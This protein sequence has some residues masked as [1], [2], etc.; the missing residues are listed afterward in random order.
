MMKALSSASCPNMPSI[1]LENLFFPKDNLNT[2]AVLS[3]T[4]LSLRVATSASLLTAM[5]SLSMSM[6]AF[7]TW[8][9]IL[10]L[11]MSSRPFHMF[12]SLMPLSGILQFSTMN[13][14]TPMTCPLILQSYLDM[15]HVTPVSTILVPSIIFARLMN[16]T[17]LTC[18]T[19]SLRN[20]PSWNVQQMPY[21]LFHNVF[22]ATSAILTFSSLT[23]D[24]SVLIVFSAPLNTLHSSITLPIISLSVATSSPVFLLP[25][26]D[27]SLN[28]ILLIPYSVMFLLPMTAFLVM[29]AVLW[30]NLTVAL[31]HTS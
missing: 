11:L 26:Y 31:T 22:I 4:H 23:S 29:V 5:S 13:F 6:T 7:T 25:M 30:H 17:S 19:I 14:M 16:F 24:G 8:T 15:I 12:F 10:L 3:M 18:L 9:C 2:L 28:G 1:P 20:L 27:A 21:L